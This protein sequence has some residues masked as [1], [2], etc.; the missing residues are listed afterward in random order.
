MTLTWGR[1]EGTAAAAA[2]SAAHG[3]P[4]GG[5]GGAGRA[6]AGVGQVAG[7]GDP[8]EPFTSFITQ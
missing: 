4:G 7:G 2:G 5:Q 6:G 1:V 8:V 3:A